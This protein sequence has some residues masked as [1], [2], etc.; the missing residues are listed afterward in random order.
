LKLL[1]PEKVTLQV[2]FE[3]PVNKKGKGVG[4]GDLIAHVKEAVEK[5]EGGNAIAGPLA[6][7]KVKRFPPNEKKE[8]A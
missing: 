7:V 3:R 8:A 2:T 1:K 6:N 4:Y 5:H